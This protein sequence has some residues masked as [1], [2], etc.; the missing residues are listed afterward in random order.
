MQGSGSIT[1]SRGRG[2]RLLHSLWIGWTFTLGFFSWL[3]FAYIGIRTGHHRWLLWAA[4][5]AAPL[6]LFGVFSEVWSESWTNAALSATLLLGVVS[7]VHAFLVRKEYLLRLDLA[8][9]ETSSVSVTSRG[10]R[11]ELLHS[12]WLGWTLLFGF[13]SWAAFLYIGIRAG[14][15]RWILWG[16]V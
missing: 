12:L 3:A 6:T 9:R 1:L 11:W 4:V 8:G 5:Y 16:L 13:T 14:R 15:A 7:I 2:W 10:R